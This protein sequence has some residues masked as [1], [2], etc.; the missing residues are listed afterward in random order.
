MRTANLLAVVSGA[1]SPR[2]PAT[3]LAR[4]VDQLGGPEDED[5]I[6]SESRLWSETCLETLVRPVRGPRIVFTHKFEG[7]TAAAAATTTTTTTT[8]TTAAATAT[9]PTTIDR[10]SGSRPTMGQ[11]APAE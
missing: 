5:E 3:S 8:T 2:R 4:P 6:D 7:P 10:A 1:V 9:A 11:I